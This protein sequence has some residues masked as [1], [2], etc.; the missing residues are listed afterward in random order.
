MSELPFIN[1]SQ[2]SVCRVVNKVARAIADLS[3]RYIQMPSEEEKKELAEECYIISGMP[4]CYSALDGTHVRIVKP[5]SNHLPPPHH[6]F[7][8]KHYYS[9]NVMVLCDIRGKVIFVSCRNPGHGH[10][11]RVYGESCL[12]LL[13]KQNFNTHE[14]YFTVGDEAYPNTDVLLTPLRNTGDLTDLEKKYN[15]CHGKARLCI[16]HCFGRI[17][18]RFPCLLYGLRSLVEH[19]KDIIMACMVLHNISLLF[20]DEP[21]CTM[22][23]EEFQSYVQFSSM[24]EIERENGPRENNSTRD[25]LLHFLDQ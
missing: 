23:Q 9:L 17:K 12:P 18:K 22:S 19:S 25:R 24:N 3:A 2:S 14:P 5:P 10:D 21:H 11:A 7:N 15:K 16:E 4:G 8:R 13:L 20:N 1:V 6:F